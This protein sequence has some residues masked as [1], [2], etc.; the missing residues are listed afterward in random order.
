MRTVVASILVRA[1]IKPQGTVGP[2]LQRLRDGEYT[3]IYSELL[4]EELADV[5]NRPRIRDKY[6]WGNA[7]IET[8]LMLVLLR[9]EAVVPNRRI[10]VCR[11]PKDN[12]V[13]EAATDGEA[14]VI[15]SGE[16]IC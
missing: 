10:A 1:L 6:H 2:V 13:L 14:V 12:R 16:R 9:G 11:D 4:L 15:V 7:D 8:V 3:M 5:L